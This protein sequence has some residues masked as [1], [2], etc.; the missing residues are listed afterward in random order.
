[1]RSQKCLTSVGVVG[2]G[3]SVMAVIPALVGFLPSDLKMSR[4]V[5]SNVHLVGLNWM[6]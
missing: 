5:D 4:D 1:M 3:I 2:R 6:P